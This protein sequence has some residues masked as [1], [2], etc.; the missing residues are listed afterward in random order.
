MSSIIALSL[1]AFGWFCSGS[2]PNEC[3]LCVPPIFLG[4]FLVSGDGMITSVAAAPA[5]SGLGAG[6]E[7]DS[8]LDL[9]EMA[10][11]GSLHLYLYRLVHK[12]CKM[13]Y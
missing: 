8:A 3:E 11:S 1:A 10:A 2:E 12:T 4:Y 6:H 5:V 13:R 7:A 9:E